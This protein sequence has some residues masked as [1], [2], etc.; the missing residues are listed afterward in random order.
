MDEIKRMKNATNVENTI[1]VTFEF[2]KHNIEM[3]ERKQMWSKVL[4][5]NLK[6]DIIITIKKK[7][8]I[9]LITENNNLEFKRELTDS[10]IKEIIAFCNTTGGTIILGYD[11]N[12]KVVGLKNA[13]EDLDRL[14]SKINDSI[15]P[16]V[17]FLVSSRI[18]IEENKEIIVVEVLRGTNKPYYIK[19]KGMIIDG[20]F[21]RLGATVQHATRETIKEMIVE[22]SGI[23]FEKN[24]SI[25]QDLT[26]TFANQLFK[27]KKI[28]F[29][30]VEKKNL[31]LVN[32]DNKYT[33]LGLL[34]SDQCPYSIK[35]ARYRDNTKTEFL[36]SKEFSEQSILSQYENAYEYLMM[37]NR[38][39]SKIDGMER[40]DEYEYPKNS[41]RELLCNTITH[42]D[43]EIN[44]SNLIHIF[45]DKIEFLSLG[46]LVSGLTIEDIKLGSSSSR[47][48]NLVN[49]FHRLNFVEA[50]GTGIPRMYEEYKASVTIPKIK[51]A[52]HSFLVILPKLKLKNEYTL[53]IEYLKQNNQGTRENF[54]TILKLGKSATINVL[55]EM[56]EKDIIE[57]TGFSK[58]VVYKLK[59]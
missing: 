9:F 47:N 6:I 3:D 7:E 52:P 12:G 31:G 42:R 51:V 55:N 14:S 21:V 53:I 34:L 35:V 5:K 49:I 11:D 22:S 44:G 39:S 16:S 54:E 19:S 15:E 1:F 10:I 41:L 17:N 24:I 20:V 38:M 26:F 33:N 32:S 58:N 28:S 36:D 57:K 29:G 4:I 18:E 30:N 40:I 43:Y 8:V 27:K 25:N 45:N 23:S 13:K 37:N 46:G 56:L 59:Q 2:L 48:P 50:Y